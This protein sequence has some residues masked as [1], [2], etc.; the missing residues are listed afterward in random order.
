MNKIILLFIPIILANSLSFGQIAYSGFIGKYPI[1]LVTDI[2]SDGAANAVYLY[3]KYNDP[4][5]ID[6]KLGK[7]TL[8]LSEVI[9]DSTSLI[10][11]NYDSK[12]DTIFGKWID[13]KNKKELSIILIKKFEIDYGKNKEWKNRELIQHASLKNL[14][15]KLLISKTKKILKHM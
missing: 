9:R 15:F 8:T 13:S 7:N 14:Y 12:K 11:D 5:T 3:K 10:F 1:E 2:A 6:A 4:I